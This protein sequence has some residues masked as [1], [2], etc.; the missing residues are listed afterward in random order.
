MLGGKISTGLLLE[1][2][3]LEMIC[4][5]PPK[6]TKTTKDEKKT[7]KWKKQELIF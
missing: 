3:D 5:H 1:T 2:V 7:D 4:L 6:E